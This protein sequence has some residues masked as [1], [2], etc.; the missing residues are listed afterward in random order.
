MKRPF[1][2]RGIGIS[3]SAWN[4]ALANL[5]EALELHFESP[6]RPQV[7]MTEILGWRALRAW[8]ESSALTAPSSHGSEDF[9]HR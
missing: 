3:R 9:T 7:R 8:V 4:L 5:K 2:A 1:G 6:R